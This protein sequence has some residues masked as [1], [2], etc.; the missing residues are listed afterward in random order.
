MP[1][2]RIVKS[3]GSAVTTGAGHPA[4]GCGAR[5]RPATS[6]DHGQERGAVAVQAREVKV[7]RRLVYL[8]LAPVLRLHRVDRQAVGFRATVPAALA[9]PLVD[10]HSLGWRGLLAALALTALLGR[11]LLVVDEDRDAGN[12]R[13][14]LLYRQQLIPAPHLGR[15]AGLPPD[16]L[17]V[18]AG[19]DD[20][21]DPL[22]AQLAD[23][24]GQREFAD[25]PLPAGHRHRRVPQQLER[26]VHPGRDCGAHHQ[27]ARVRE[28][29][30]AY[31]LDEVRLRHER[32]HAQPLCPL[33]AHLAQPGQVAGPVARHQQQHGVT[34]DAAAD[35]CPRA[36]LRG[37]V[38]RA[39]RAEERVRLA[40]GRLS[41]VAP[42]SGSGAAWLMSSLA[43]VLDS[44]QAIAAA[45]SSP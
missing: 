34:S 17:R 26:D 37:R 13:E 16:R 44:G 33:A 23:K 7:A 42:R 43:S 6:G 22:A 28:G 21:R 14:V 20:A 27:A 38:V 11:A 19:D 9:H 24:V 36:H 35:E 8:G 40:I 12:G 31:V 4:A 39:A 32:R 2:I 30:V 25:R 3:A 10:Q 5:L 18:V 29:P 41:E 1:V 15:P 45:S